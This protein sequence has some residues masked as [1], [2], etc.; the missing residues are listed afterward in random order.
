MAFALTRVLPMAPLGWIWLNLFLFEVFLLLTVIPHELGHAF[1]GRYNGFEVF[2]IIVGI[3]RTVWSGKIF[4]FDTEIKS[5]P[6]GG[7]TMAATPDVTNYRRRHFALVFA[8]PLTNLLLAAVVLLWCSWE[9][10]ADWRRWRWSVEP[11]AMF[12]WANMLLLLLNLVPR[13]FQTV[14]GPVGSDGRQLW[15]TLFLKPAKLTERVT[16]YYLLKVITA[17]QKQNQ[18]EIRHWLEAGRKEFPE[19]ESLLSYEGL[20]A[21]ERGDCASARRIF[22]EILARGNCSAVVRYLMLNNIAYADAVLAEPGRQEEAEL[23]SK[24]ALAGLGWIPCVKGTR[25]SVL[26]NQGK[27]DEALKLLKEALDGNS[28]VV[29]RAQNACWLAMGECQRRNYDEARRFLKMAEELDA[30]CFMLERAR[31][32]C[33]LPE[34]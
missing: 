24:E 16:A 26:L 10:L 33:A 28:T 11:A 3:G 34:V 1:A 14:V 15:E 25:G 13:K 5:V 7:I 20:V 23:Y 30:G 27:T 19:N 32:Y 8:G 17:Y 21:M 29:G 12:F 31:S 18:A 2:R 6:A 4:G 22:E 9:E